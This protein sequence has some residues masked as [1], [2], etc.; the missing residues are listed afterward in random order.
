MD[1]DKTTSF[2]AAQ[3][4]ANLL[5]CLAILAKIFNDVGLVVAASAGLYFTWLG[6]TTWKREH[7]GKVVWDLARRYAKQALFVRDEIA[8]IR[9]SLRWIPP[10]EEKTE[11]DKKLSQ[12][13]KEFRAYQKFYSDAMNKLQEKYNEL[14]IL[15]LEL[16]VTGYKEFETLNANL[17][18]LL[19]TFRF[20]LTQHL[21][22]KQDARKAKLTHQRQGEIDQLLFANHEKTDEYSLKLAELFRRM[23]EQSR[24]IMESVHGLRNRRPR[25]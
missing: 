4:S 19:S 24:E 8:L 20:A 18:G 11:A 21:H 7:I 25:S 3:S 1:T 12:A 5:E 22:H 9:E 17:Q 2:L 23:E 14:R 13:E 6:L 15:A 10:Y 16:R